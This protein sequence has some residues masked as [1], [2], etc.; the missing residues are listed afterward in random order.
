MFLM[1][2]YHVV[3]TMGLILSLTGCAD[4][5][6]IMRPPAPEK[7]PAGETPTLETTESVITVPVQLDLSDFLQAANNPT[8]IAKQVDH[9]GSVIKHPNGG[10]FKYYAERGDFTIEQSGSQQAGGATPRGPSQPG[11]L[12]D[13]WKGIDLS[14]SSL[15]VNAP[16]RYKIGFRPPGVGTAPGQCGDGPDWPRRAAL[17]GNIAL[18][19]TPRYGVA[20]S[21]RGVTVTP[22]DPCRLSPANL[23]AQGAVNA[24]LSD[25]V[26]GGLNRA[27]SLL[28]ALTVKSRAEEVWSALRN[29]I[30]LEED[31][32]LLLN[33]EKMG[34][35][36]FSKAGHTLQNTLE[37]TAHPVI[38]HG[39]EPFVTPAALPQLET[40]PSSA[41]FRGVADVQGG[42]S[43]SQP[44][45]KKFHV[46]TDVQI[47]YGTFSKR[48][49]DRLRGTRIVHTRYFIRVTGAKVSGLGANQVLLRVDFAGDA[50]GHLYLIG[51]PEINTMTQTVYLS[52]LRYDLKTAQ[53]LQDGA[54]DWLHHAPLREVIT[55]EIMFGVQPMV[56]HW[57][58]LLQTG[59]NRTLNPTISLQGTVTSMS[60]IAVLADV[61]ALHVHAV[62]DG[63]LN[64]MTDSEP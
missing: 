9:W 13:W 5:D 27:V 46:L 45:S 22:L 57:R 26:T 41:D 17:T 25:Q 21:V 6:F 24:K 33:I 64:V 28:N 54:P 19:M 61:D 47:D 36:G 59:L 10:E 29:P 42:D 16:L 44:G 62:S 20:A 60:G 31:A 8:V 14:G 35:R 55:P 7:L 50:H 38:I 52:G 37:I 49:A 2:R 30:P 3:A 18:A 15:Y 58:D 43:E 4:T 40:E 48:V 53:L 51:K 63:I 32:W 11:S 56:D 39:A 34:H 12:G 23:E 1:S